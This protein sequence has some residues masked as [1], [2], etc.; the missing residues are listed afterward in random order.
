MAEIRRTDYV[1]S[2]DRGDGAMS[3]MALLMLLRRMGQKQVTVHGFR[4][5]FRDW[6][7]EQTNFTREVAEQALAHSL[8][9]ATEAAYPPCRHAEQAQA[10][11][12]GMGQILHH[13]SS[14]RQGNADQAEGV[15]TMPRKL[16]YDRERRQHA[17]FARCIR[18][19]DNGYRKLLL[20]YLRSDTPLSKE[21]RCVL[22][23]W[24][25]R[26]DMWWGKKPQPVKDVERFH[27]PS[28]AQRI[29]RRRE[30]G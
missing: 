30:R 29:L 9:D 6:C 13:A 22:A 23:D 14:E 28:R 24:L 15:I 4:S 16:T 12:A 5:T 10:I 19:A 8:P 11:D 2:N 3:N 26:L 18:E 1:F 25:G 7:A 17:L 21:Q 27:H 20:A